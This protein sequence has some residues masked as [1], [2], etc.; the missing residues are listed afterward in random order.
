MRL[1]FKIAVYMVG[2]I[3]FAVI[4]L[5][6]LT[7][8]KFR[9]LQEEVER[10][11]FLVLALDIKATAE[12]GLALGLGLEQMNNLGGILERLH[13]E[14]PEI[15]SLQIV[16]DRGETLHTVGAALEGT[17][18]ADRLARLQ[19]QG[20]G[21]PSRPLDVSDDT[22]FGLML[23]LVNAFGQIPGAVVLHY[24]RAPS[25]AAARAVTFD[26]LRVGAVALL[27]AALAA[28]ALTSF[29]LRGLTHGFARMTRLV[30]WPTDGAQSNENLPPDDLERR[31]QAVR[32]Q[33]QELEGKVDR[34]ESALGRRH[35]VR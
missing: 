3:A 31:F 18:F 28:L 26:Q 29:Y 22:A 25:A 23:P 27:L 14:H 5:T 10:S 21:E 13:G 6:Y 12:R 33:V 11:R 15:L 9:S 17:S 7:N 4:L 16:S 8:A 2:I 35:A 34:A 32:A 19:V 20:N 30:E 24:D 1:S